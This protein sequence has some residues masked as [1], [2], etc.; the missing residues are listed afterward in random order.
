[1]QI[2][3]HLD[4]D[5][6][7]GTIGLVIAAAAGA[8]TAFLAIRAMFAPRPRSRPQPQ[9]YEQPT[10]PREVESAPS[11]MME[12]IPVAPA[13]RF[14]LLYIPERKHQHWDLVEVMPGGA[15]KW[16]QSFKY[17]ET[18]KKAL[19]KKLDSVQ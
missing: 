6:N 17:H 4:V 16:L 13:V 3:T 14:Q 19:E 7:M 1:M 9:Q 18:A 5:P 10:V 15:H 8:A 2:P 11:V 12:K